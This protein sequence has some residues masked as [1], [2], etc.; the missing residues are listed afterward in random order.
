[1]NDGPILSGR[2]MF[3]GDAAFLASSA[4][5]TLKTPPDPQLLQEAVNQAAKQ[6]PW[7]TYGVR[8]EDGLFYATLD[9]TEP[10]ARQYVALRETLGLR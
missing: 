9:A 1:M 8:E 6:H 5:A 10:G 3:Y 4:K 2:M 7:A